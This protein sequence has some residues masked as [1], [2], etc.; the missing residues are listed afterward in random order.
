MITEQSAMN[1]VAD[2]LTTRSFTT[3]SLTAL[4]SS[5]ADIKLFSMNTT[6][7]I[8]V[9]TQ[10]A[11]QLPSSSLF[12]TVHRL[13]S[14][15][16]Q[17][18]DY[19]M[20]N[21]D[22]SDDSSESFIPPSLQQFFTRKNHRPSSKTQNTLSKGSNTSETESDSLSFT[23]GSSQSPVISNTYFLP[24]RPLTGKTTG[25]YFHP[26]T[27]M[28]IQRLPNNHSHQKEQ[29][30]QIEQMLASV[31]W[32]AE[33]NSSNSSNVGRHHT[34]NSSSVS[35]A[36]LNLK[37]AEST[38]YP[39]LEQS[40]LVSPPKG[41]SFASLSSASDYRMIGNDVDHSQSRGYSDPTFDMHPET[42]A[43]VADSFKALCDA[44][45]LPLCHRIPSRFAE[46]F[47]LEQVHTATHLDNTARIAGLTDL[48]MDRLEDR[49]EDTYLCKMTPAAAGFSCGGAIAACESVWT[50]QVTNAFAL[51]RPPGHHA[52]AH[53]PMGFCFYNNVAIATRRM[54][55]EFNV[56][57]IMIVDWDIHHGNGTQA[58]FYDDPNVLFISIHRFEDGRF[59]PNYRVAGPEWIGG[60][61]A[62]GRNINVAWPCA[63]LGDADYMQVFRD[64]IMPIG[65]EFDPDLVIVSAGFDAAHGDPI[66]ECHVTPACYSQMTHMLKS[67]ANG[68]LVLVLEG[69]Y[70]VPVV[71]TSVV[72]CMGVLLGLPPNPISPG[73]P[74]KAALQT[75]A[76]LKLYLE[77]HWKCIPKLFDSSNHQR[78]AKLFDTTQLE[79]AD[80]P[81]S[82][83]L[84]KASLETKNTKFPVTIISSSSSALSVSSGS[85][86]SPV[87][88]SRPF[89]AVVPPV[90]TEPPT[91]WQEA[92]H[93]VPLSLSKAIKIYGTKGYHST[94]GFLFV[95]MHTYMPPSK[96][97]KR[98]H[99][100][101]DFYAIQEF[102]SG[103]I[104][105]GH[106][107]IDIE[108][109][110]NESEL[111]GGQKDKE[112]AIRNISPEAISILNK[113]AISS[114][115]LFF[116][117]IDI[118]ISAVESC[119][120]ASS[121]LQCSLRHVVLAGQFHSY[122]V[123]EHFKIFLVRCCDVFVPSALA[124]GEL[125]ASPTHQ[126]LSVPKLYSWGSLNSL[127]NEIIHKFSRLVYSFIATALTIKCQLRIKRFIANGAD[128]SG[129][130]PSGSNAK[131]VSIV[132]PEPLE[133]PPKRKNAS[134]SGEN[135]DSAATN[136]A[137]QSQP[138]KKSRVEDKRGESSKNDSNPSLT[139]QSD[140][141]QDTNQSKSFRRSN[142]SETRSAIAFKPNNT[143][144]KSSS[145]N[146]QSV[147]SIINASPSHSKVSLFL[148]KQNLD[149]S[150]YKPASQETLAMTTENKPKSLAHYLSSLHDD[151]K[152]K[153][154]P[155]TP[156]SIDITDLTVD[157]NL[158]DQDSSKANLTTPSKV[159]NK[160]NGI[161]E[162]P[163]KQS[164]HSTR[165]NQVSVS[166][167]KVVKSPVSKTIKASNQEK[168]GLGKTHGIDS[169]TVA[170]PS[171]QH[172]VDV[173]EP[174]GVAGVAMLDI[175][176]VDVFGRSIVNPL[177]T[178]S[179]L[180]KKSV[181]TAEQSKLVGNSPKSKLRDNASKDVSV[182]D[183]SIDFDRTT[184]PHSE[185][186]S[187]LNNKSVSNV[188]ENIDDEMEASDDLLFPALNDDNDV[189]V[190]E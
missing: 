188:A 107:I 90:R 137:N 65:Q 59:Y 115:A 151:S 142:S 132:H 112:K 114:N 72:A 12:S 97:S 58:E 92:I 75:I 183:S 131:M 32:P 171:S 56:Q 125:V 143:A 31:K 167:S 35:T 88:P 81:T 165:A 186:A 138:L 95:V 91:F 77:P 68:R 157:L 15:N 74:C 71:K 42:P 106:H 87:A 79:K 96:V 133:R 5:I 136:R 21:H 100:P 24:P 177:P 160:T 93:L 3:R 70:H 175:D 45:F 69:G 166:P 147:S 182:L 94:S 7:A 76:E 2:P 174:N 98:D 179:N 129:R 22:S 86:V 4:S 155:S 85:S 9:D 144:T 116:I 66:G 36:A 20:D 44:G 8:A 38:A 139:V 78:E 158:P 84:T 55:S 40:V 43:R 121:A 6:E 122:I 159:P 156:D 18:S 104:S 189:N 13:P 119:I 187:P 164:K 150:A 173:Y 113:K 48:Q 134:K 73:P 34:K 178:G 103:L 11:H 161:A 109:H 154:R 102:V 126:T 130:I 152:S 153:A 118:P 82:L 17:T 123:Q 51:V 16:V 23:S 1:S 62:R 190:I 140:A 99:P 172:L 46:R 105:H 128:L 111:K 168:N 120:E 39:H 101:Y 145:A 149:I 169:G 176:L 148:P 37:H 170:Q 89:A 67:L 29:L 41:H 61:Q 47:E 33:K 52:E 80:A 49:Y 141:D 124:L 127:S 108:L 25:L 110:L 54:K 185:E 28:H 117:G 163:S 181:D 50:N 63:G 26:S 53:R 10:S 184:L 60:K 146:R 180:F 83:A 30:F 64:L 162:S 27:L 19:I 14:L 135:G 57:R